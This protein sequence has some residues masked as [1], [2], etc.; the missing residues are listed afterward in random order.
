M[1]IVITGDKYT[2]KTGTVIVYDNQKE[3]FSI[4]DKIIYKGERYIIER[5]F[6]PTRPNGKWSLSVVNENR[7]NS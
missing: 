5:I 7:S 4:G 6:P 2:T 3:R 1:T